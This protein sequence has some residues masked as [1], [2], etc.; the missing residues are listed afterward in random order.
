MLPPR[1]FPFWRKVIRCTRAA[2]LLYVPHCKRGHFGSPER[3]TEKYSDDGA[4]ARPLSVVMSGALRSEQ[5]IKLATRFLR[6]TDRVSKPFY[7]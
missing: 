3:A 6:L 5:T 1:T 4:V 2:A 7:S